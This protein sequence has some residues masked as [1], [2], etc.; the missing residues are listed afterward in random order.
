MA[1]TLPNGSTFD[2]ASGYSAPVAVTAISNA[3]EAVVDAAG[4]TFVDG[5]IV[6]LTSGWLKLSGR[7]FRI[8]SVVATTSFVLEGIDTSD[9]SRYPLNGGIGSVRK[10]ESFIQIPQILDVTFAG[11][12]QNFTS[13]VFLEDSEERQIPTTKSASSLTL[14]I[15]DD[16]SQ[17]FIPFVEA[18]DEDT[19]PR[20]QRLNL[21]NGDIILYNSIVSF[22]S[23]PTLTRDEVMARTLTLS[24]QGK[25]V[26]YQAE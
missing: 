6:E 23:T 18:A 4:H 10:V 20:V 26:R 9:V 11:G 8:K 21:V 3:V 5:D 19:K 16:P 15:A 2:F 24:Q 12:E 22:T 1:Y 13:V 17:P 7:A 25:I 14:T